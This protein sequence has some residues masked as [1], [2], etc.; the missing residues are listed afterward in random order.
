MEDIIGAENKWTVQEVVKECSISRPTVQK[1]LK[2]GELKGVQS[3]KSK[4][5]YIDPAEA[6]RWEPTKKKRP[7]PAAKVIVQNDQTEVVNLLKEQVQQ[8]QD[9]L[10]VKDQQ[11]ATAQGTLDKQTLMLEHHQ[12]EGKK[13]FFKRLFSSP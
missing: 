7:S 4:K 11:L 5:W 1:A 13:G 12:Q 2:A 3:G 6:R 10:E 9:Q 8:L